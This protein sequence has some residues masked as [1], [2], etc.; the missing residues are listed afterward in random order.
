MRAAL[1]DLER[2]PPTLAGLVAAAKRGEARDLRRLRA[3]VALDESLE[4]AQCR[5][6]IVGDGTAR[7]RRE[8]RMFRLRNS[9]GHARERRHQ[10]AL[11]DILDKV[12]VDRRDDPIQYRLGA[13]PSAADAR[14]QPGNRVVGELGRRADSLDVVAVIPGIAE[15]RHLRGA[16]EDGVHATQRREHQRV[17]V[18]K[19]LRLDGE[20][21]LVQEQLVRNPV[22]AAQRLRVQRLQA[23][24]SAALAR[25]HAFE[26]GE[27]QVRQKTVVA[28]NAANSRLDGIAP[29][30]RVEIFVE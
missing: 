29:E 27:R 4:A 7:S 11:L 15:R 5:L 6:V 12:R 2:S 30:R 19:L 21:H 26:R 8:R 16:R 10:R 24:Q 9:F 3:V 1:D 17:G 20:L 28:W 13:H 23:L 18:G 25:A 22:L 14:P